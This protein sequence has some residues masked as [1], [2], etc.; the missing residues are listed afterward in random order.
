MAF[1]DVVFLRSATIRA[2]SSRCAH[3]FS[4]KGNHVAV[5]AKLKSWQS[6]KNGSTR[7]GLDLVANDI[8]Y[9][10]AKE[11][12]APPKNRI[13][14]PGHGEAT[15]IEGSDR[16]FLDGISNRAVTSASSRKS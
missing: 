4:F 8:L 13:Q 11:Q 14:P 10:D 3:Q 15:V 7:Y 2:D 16:P 6:K 9:L 5:E 12:A 1:K